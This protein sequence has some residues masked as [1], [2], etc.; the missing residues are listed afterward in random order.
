MARHDDIETEASDVW[1]K[2]EANALRLY[3]AHWKKNGKNPAS[4]ARDVANA[5]TLSVYKR[6]LIFGTTARRRLPRE[7]KMP[8]PRGCAFL[9]KLHSV[10]FARMV[11]GR[12][13]GEIGVVLV[14]PSTD[15]LW[16]P[17]L[18]A[19]VAFPG[20][21]LGPPIEKAARVP[22][23]AAIYRIWH[24]GREPW[25]ASRMRMPDPRFADAQPAIATGYVSDKFSD[26]GE[27]VE[28]LHHH[29]QDVFCWWGPPGASTPQ[30][31]L[32]RGGRLAVTAGG[33]IG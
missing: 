24:K 14:P 22:E 18:A 32:V 10:H 29:E 15:C 5:V 27:L 2:L 16:S 28:Y 1:A 3:S 23:A 25:G 7:R 6:A 8:N 9:G 12:P 33:L 31:I 17:R 4:H 13:T 26:D 21:R 30:A 20:Q 19:V 11:A